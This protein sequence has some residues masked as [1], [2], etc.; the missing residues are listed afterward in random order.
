MED[1]D[2]LC[3]QHSTQLLIAKEGTHRLSCI[4]YFKDYGPQPFPFI[5][6]KLSLQLTL[7]GACPGSM[8]KRHC[9]ERT[10]CVCVGI[11]HHSDPKICMESWIFQLKLFDDKVDDKIWQVL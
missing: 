6:G 9:L 2:S 3:E 8:N 7:R 5:D 10:Y 11:I 4:R 1:L